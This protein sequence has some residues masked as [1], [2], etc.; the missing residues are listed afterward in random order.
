MTLI[1]TPPET[2]WIIAARRPEL[3]RLV[4]ETRLPAL[5][6][7]AMLNR[8][9][10]SGP[11]MQAFLAPQI[12]D[13]L[14]PSETPGA[15]EAGRLLARAARDGRRIVLYGDYDVDGVTSIAILWHILRLQTDNVAWYVPSRFEEGYGVNAE[16]L[17]SLRA[18]GAEIVV[19]VDCGIT[20]IDEARLA[21]ELGI[22][23]IITDHHE[24][25]S[26][27][28]DAELLVHPTALGAS[29][30][31]HLSG[32]GVA[33]K[34]AW[35]LAQE[36]SGGGRA[37]P[38]FRDALLDSTA[39]AALGLIADV[40]PLTG[41]N[42]VIAAY[43]LRQLCHT[44][45][46]GLNALIEV[47]GV[48]GKETYDDYDVGFRLAPRLN[49]VGRMG[50]AAAAVELFTT[51]DAPRAR[52]IAEMLDERNRERQ[53]VEREIT[54]AAEQM[55]IERGFHLDGCRGIVLAS[56]DWHSGVIGIVASRLVERF[57]RPTV[58]IALNN[59]VGQGSGRS[60]RHFPLHEALQACAAHLIGFGGH[61]MAAGVRVESANMDAF[62]AAFQA[63]AAQRLTAADL[64]PKLRLDDEAPL[65][66]L[67][68][69]AVTALRRMAPFGPGNARPRFASAPLELAEPPKVVGNGKHLALVVREGGTVRRAIAFGRGPDAAALE[70]CARLRLAFEPQ[71][72]VWQGRERVELKV[73]D[74]KLE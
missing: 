52:E 63:E 42:R 55:V 35:A 27:L 65:R 37:L 57:G 3:D 25:K 59:G 44:R 48:A 53:A 28:P 11:D 24:P 9:I 29:R 60:V 50:H 34:V 46:H 73:V 54:D 18:D 4:R 16:A 13:L 64:R 23:L 14:P 41:E 71:V 43:G 19:T 15:V 17:R 68:V 74:W 8:D 49:A 26:E 51:A 70:E 39:F 10:A 30:N 62:T 21:R 69:S 5:V 6:V 7:Q 32:A 45:N 2:E 12:R 33:L 1:Y 56:T 61:A 20:A 72:S 67:S 38:A 22:T 36:L 66:E 47:S 40:V 31:P 58:L